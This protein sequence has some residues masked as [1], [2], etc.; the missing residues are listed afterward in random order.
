MPTLTVEI[1]SATSRC[2]REI[3]TPSDPRPADATFA[4]TVLMHRMAS[5][6]GGAISTPLS[7]LATLRG[8]GASGLRGFGA[9]GLRGFGASG[10]RGD[11]G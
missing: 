11:A 10:L 5:P 1:H 8:F 7:A 2:R 4:L 6:L 9:S 3:F